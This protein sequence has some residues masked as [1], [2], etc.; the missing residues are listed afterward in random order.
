MQPETA[1]QNYFRAKDGNL[2]HLMREVFSEDALLTFDVKAPGMS[3]PDVARGR[4]SITDVRVS[5]FGE[6]YDH[7]RSFYLDR[8]APGVAE[9]SCDWLV[10]MRHRGDGEIRVGCGRYEWKFQ[11]IEPGL[12]TELRIT[13]ESMQRLPAGELSAIQAWFGR[14]DYPWTSAHAAA[15]QAPANPAPVPVLRYLARG[16]R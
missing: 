3:F 5:G 7:V 11:A 10:G 15:A 6:T 2:P 14:L 13:I 4:D 9:F 12:A 16:A 1:L 8:P